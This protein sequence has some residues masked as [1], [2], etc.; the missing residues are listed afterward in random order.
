MRGLFVPSTCL[1]LAIGSPSSATPRLLQ[2]RCNSHFYFFIFYQL[3][4]YSQHLGRPLEP[5]ITNCN[6]VFLL[7]LFVFLSFASKSFVLVNSNL[8]FY[9]IFCICLLLHSNGVALKSHSSSAEKTPQLA[10]PWSAPTL[11]L[12][13]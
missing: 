6:V 3:F 8:Y 13:I 4:V 1:L 9:C 7:F 10:I 5:F 11:L 2:Q 12:T